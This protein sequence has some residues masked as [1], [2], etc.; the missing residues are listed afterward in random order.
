MKTKGIVQNTSIIRTRFNMQNTRLTITLSDYIAGEAPLVIPMDVLITPIYATPEEVLLHFT[1]E[2]S[3]EWVE[4]F[5]RVL[6]LIFNGSRAF[7]RLLALNSI[8]I[9]EVVMRSAAASQYAICYA[10]YWAGIKIFKD[11]LK[12]VSKTKNL[13]DF[14]VS[15]RGDQ[16]TLP[17]DS[18]IVDAKKCMDDLKKYVEDLASAEIGKAA[19]FQFRRIGA[20]VVA[21][22]TRRWDY[23]V[24]ELGIAYAGN[25]RILQDGSSYKT[26]AY[27][28]YWMVGK[29]G[30][31]NWGYDGYFSW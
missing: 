19:G 28:Q 11:K 5:E 21:G 1:D 22:S 4:N 18:I 10:T 31:D 25:K 2:G 26:G 3:S 17:I 8:E 13:G 12:S 24:P 29:L 14:Q 7:D 23:M 27:Y 9:S 6:N 15:Y 16:N 30:Y 20:K